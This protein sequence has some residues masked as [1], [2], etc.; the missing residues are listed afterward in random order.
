MADIQQLGKTNAFGPCSH[1]DKDMTAMAAGMLK[2][3]IERIATGMATGIMHFE[4]KWSA[5]VC[6]EIKMKYAYLGLKPNMLTFTPPA[7]PSNGPFVVGINQPTEFYTPKLGL[8]DMADA[9]RNGVTEAIPSIIFDDW[10]SCWAH[11]WRAVD[12]HKKKL[13]DSSQERVNELFTD[14]AFLHEM[15]QKDLYQHG[16]RLFTDKWLY[17]YR[18][19]DMVEYLKHEL[20]KRKFAR[21][22]SNPGKPTDNNCLE[23]L[24]RVLKSESHF[25]TVEGMGTVLERS[26]LVGGRL[27][28]HTKV[29]LSLN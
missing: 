16:V 24:N 18:E 28:R 9:L 3:F 13:H 20:L 6:T 11:G 21:C 12:K 14:L 2:Q 4:S 25:D 17:K 10:Q 23:G 26:V 8:S 27:G 19:A 15:P 22:H 7:G 5:S 1:E 29:R